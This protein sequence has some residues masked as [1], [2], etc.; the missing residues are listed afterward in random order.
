MA[1]KEQVEDLLEDPGAMQKDAFLALLDKEDAE[2]IM[3]AMTT[4]VLQ[5]GEILA[6]EGEPQ[7]EAYL[8]VRG[9]IEKSRQGEG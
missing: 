1:N 2:K 9:S 5:K 8:I 3:N 7:K 6:K 4:R